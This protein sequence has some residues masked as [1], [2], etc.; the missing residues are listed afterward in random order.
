MWFLVLLPHLFQSGSHKNLRSLQNFSQR[1]KRSCLLP[2]LCYSPQN[3][4]FFKK[5]YFGLAIYLFKILLADLYF[6]FLSANYCFI[7]LVTL[8]QK[9]FSTSFQI[10]CFYVLETQFSFSYFP[11]G[12]LIPRK[13][14]HL[15]NADQ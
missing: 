13:V 1:V 12:F 10:K 6:Y 4:T 14:Q 3:Y 2:N 8:E 11:S 5:N 7:T 9:V 15:K